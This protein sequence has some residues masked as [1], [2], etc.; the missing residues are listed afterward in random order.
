[1]DESFVNQISDI[2]VVIRFGDQLGLPEP[3]KGLAEGEAIE[4]QGEYIDEN[5]VIAGPDNQQRLPVLHFTHRPVGF[6]IYK[7]TEYR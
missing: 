4:L 2:F 3:I 5:H 7:G 1:V 6:I